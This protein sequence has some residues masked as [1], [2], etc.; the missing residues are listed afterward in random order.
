LSRADLLQTTQQDR[1]PELEDPTRIAMLGNSAG[2][3]LAQGT[4]VAADY[5]YSGPLSSY[6]AS[7]AAAV[8]TGAFLTP[9]LS[10]LTLTDTDAP[11][12]M[13]M[14]AYDNASHITGAYAFE[15]CDALRAAGDA[16]HEVE[17]AGTGHTTTLT[18]GGPWWANELGPFIWDHLRLSTAAH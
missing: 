8:S 1:D 2:G 5:P 12:L 13:F 9:A 15:T 3:A 16:C 14:Y 7:I 10:T 11:S 6:S 17:Q 18:F 4:G